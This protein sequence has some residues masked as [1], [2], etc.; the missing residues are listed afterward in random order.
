MGKVLAII[1]LV[2][3]AWYAVPIL[4]RGIWI[5]PTAYDTESWWGDQPFTYDPQVAQAGYGWFNFDPR[6][7]N[8]PGQTTREVLDSIKTR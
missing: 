3:F 2:V 1:F 8:G 4:S 5:A 6:K 7:P